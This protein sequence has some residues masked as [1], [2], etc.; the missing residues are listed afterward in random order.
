MSSEDI[1]QSSGS[2]E[3]NER[4]KLGGELIGIGSRVL[5]KPDDAVTAREAARKARELT[6]R[7][8]ALESSSLPGKLCL[9][10]A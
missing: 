10:S 7:K 5:D 4:K 9:L 3:T 1:A 2:P 6:R 8:S